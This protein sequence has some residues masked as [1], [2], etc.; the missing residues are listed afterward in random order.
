MFCSNPNLMTMWLEHRLM[1]Q[2]L[3]L[4][5]SLLITTDQSN[6]FIALDGGPT[7]LVIS[8]PLLPPL[9]NK[10][11]RYAEADSHTNHFTF[12]HA[13]RSLLEDVKTTNSSNKAKI[14]PEVSKPDI[15]YRFQ[16]DT[17]T[18][19]NETLNKKS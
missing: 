7:H 13:C 16:L 11:Q 2:E 4:L 19:K 12:D 10:T 18:T 9:M 8:Q 15:P 17:I 1:N 14:D 6:V 3:C 5:A